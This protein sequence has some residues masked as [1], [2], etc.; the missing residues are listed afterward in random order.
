VLRPLRGKITLPVMLKIRN[1]PFDRHRKAR[2]LMLWP[3]RVQS[4]SSK[5]LCTAASTDIVPS[6]AHVIPTQ[7]LDADGEHVISLPVRAAQISR[8]PAF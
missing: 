6:G 4:S 2:V 3:N 5:F 8:N 1:G 7:F